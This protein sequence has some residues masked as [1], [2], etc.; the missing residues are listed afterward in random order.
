MPTAAAE[1]LA[2]L[3]AEDELSE[4]NIIPKPFDPR[5]VPRVAMRVAESAMK[6]GVARVQIDDLKAY[7]KAVFDRINK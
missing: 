1:A 2:G 7:E 3:I 6:C 5:V 4:E